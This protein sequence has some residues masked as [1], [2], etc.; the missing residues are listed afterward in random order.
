MEQKGG[1]GGG[2]GGALSEYRALS[3]SWVNVMNWRVGPNDLWCV[4][5]VFVLCLLLFVF[6]CVCVVSCCVVLCR[7][8]VLCCVVLCRLHHDIHL[9]I[10]EKTKCPPPPFFSPARPPPFDLLVVCRKFY[11]DLQTE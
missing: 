2:G 4:C 11:V 5:V 7:S 8:V 1:E 10:M 3:F 6:C 9:Y